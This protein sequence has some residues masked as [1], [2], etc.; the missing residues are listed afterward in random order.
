MYFERFSWSKSVQKMADAAFFYVIVCF[1]FLSS[2]SAFLFN[3]IKSHKWNSQWTKDR[4]THKYCVYDICFPRATNKTFLFVKSINRRNKFSGTRQI[5][6]HSSK[7]RLNF[8]GTADWT[9]HFT[10][11]WTV[12]SVWPQNC[13]NDL[14]PNQWNWQIATT[15]S[16]G[17]AQSW[18]EKFNANNLYCNLNFETQHLSQ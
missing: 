4:T 13:V 6:A 10:W 11:Y 17:T 2:N 3:K 12:R 8:G 5:C 14:H 18:C 1:C 16:N 7:N 9:S 15:M